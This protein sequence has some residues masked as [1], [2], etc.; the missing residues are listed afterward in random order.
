MAVHWAL[1]SSADEAR[2]REEALE[3]GIH[4]AVVAG[5]HQP[6]WIARTAR[7]LVLITAGRSAVGGAAPCLTV[8]PAA[9]N[10]VAVSMQG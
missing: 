2:R 9:K 8:P 4:K 10:T 1:A 3:R 6:G 5:V 7:R